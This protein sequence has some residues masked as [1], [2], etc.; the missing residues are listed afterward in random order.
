LQKITSVNSSDNF[1]FSDCD[2]NN[3]GFA[4]SSS[5]QTASR[6]GSR[7]LSVSQ[8]GSSAQIHLG[9]ELGFLCNVPV[10]TPHEG[11]HA[12]NV[13]NKKKDGLHVLLVS[14]SCLQLKVNNY[15]I[16]TK[17]VRNPTGN[18][19]NGTNTRATVAADGLSVNIRNGFPN[20]FAVQPFLIS[21]PLCRA[22]EFPGTI[23][24]YYEVKGDLRM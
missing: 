2:N 12:L 5:S 11:L 24:Y 19:Y 10:Q 18:R 1:Y 16:K 6:I 23:C 13:R 14:L 8:A 17:R 20:V 9:I 4:S 3:G 21:G 15:R 7:D 22:D